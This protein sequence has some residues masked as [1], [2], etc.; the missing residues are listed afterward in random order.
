M[1]DDHEAVEREARALGAE[2]A[3][4]KA[5]RSLCTFGRAVT[6][7]SLRRNIRHYPA[8]PWLMGFLLLHRNQKSTCCAV[9]LCKFG[10]SP[11]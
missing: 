3:V 5:G 10:A 8:R 7:Q 1:I 2:S 11:A 4:L 9:S 6:L